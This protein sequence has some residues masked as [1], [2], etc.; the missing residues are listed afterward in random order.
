MIKY[1]VMID[2]NNLSLDDLQSMANAQGHAFQRC[3]LAIS[4]PAYVRSADLISLTSSPRYAPPLAP[5]TIEMD[6]Y[7]NM[8]EE[9][10]DAD[11]ALPALKTS[12]LSLPDELLSCIARSVS[13]CGGHS[14]SSLSLT[15]RRLSS[16]STPLLW[17]SLVLP[18]TDLT[19]DA[20]FAAIL[21][22][23]DRRRYI[24]SFK[25]LLPTTPIPFASWAI[26]LSS[27]PGL[28]RV[29][30]FTSIPL[31]S[32]TLTGTSH[33]FSAE[34]SSAP[35]Q[36]ALVH[37][38]RHFSL[39]SLDSLTLP[40]TY[41][42]VVPTTLY[43]IS[44]PRLKTLCLRAEPPKSNPRSFLTSTAAGF[45]IILLVPTRFPS[46]HTLHLKGWFDSLPDRPPIK[47]EARA[48]A[49]KERRL[50]RFK[51]L[52]QAAPIN[53]R[54]A[55]PYYGSNRLPPL[56]T[57]APAPTPPQQQQR[58]LKLHLLPSLLHPRP[59]LP[60]PRPPLPAIPSS[61]TPSSDSE[62]MEISS[63]D[64][65]PPS[66]FPVGSWKIDPP[67]PALSFDH[68]SFDPDPPSYPNPPL[69]PLIYPSPL[70][71][72]L[73]PPPSLPNNISAQIDNLLADSDSDM[74]LDES[75][76]SPSDL[77]VEIATIELV[78][79]ALQDDQLGE[80]E[81]GTPS[82]SNVDGSELDEDLFQRYTIGEDWGA[83]AGEGGRDE[84][85]GGA[86]G[87]EV[88]FDEGEELDGIAWI[89][90]GPFESPPIELSPV[91][92][93]PKELELHRMTES[94][95]LLHDALA[96]GLGPGA[97]EFR[98]DDTDDGGF[99]EARSHIF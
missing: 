76:P 36:A 61:P 18:Q 39:S 78:T 64:D 24:T 47:D 53:A 57:P 74:D 23:P 5:P 30:D 67:T 13:P 66:F 43:P 77:Q 86:E 3:N 26:L 40:V 8:E 84:E 70:G 95:D 12:L 56:P 73:P 28:R 90:D 34:P 94:P 2:E 32:F 62:P 35:T 87:I 58:R 98:D 63:G 93:S 50:D 25:I 88:D 17:E 38:L 15:S 51:R 29:E 42:F 4:G 49:D 96:V 79:R 11:A 31:K 82:S 16:I 91:V 54:L 1:N 20:L 69:I 68:L 27:L 97:V 60:P 71:P 7:G 22:D 33:V 46:L 9:M 10:P 99:Q 21:S 81:T 19:R 85:G 72:S 59:P 89:E 80:V 83:G 14:I 52:Q 55:R 65:L 45:L 41:P 75:S 6:E 44:M 48:G 37:I 92:C